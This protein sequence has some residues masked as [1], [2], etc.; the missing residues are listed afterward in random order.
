[1]CTI[2]TKSFLPFGFWSCRALSAA[3]IM[4]VV[5]FSWCFDSNVL[6]KFHIMNTA[7]AEYSLIGAFHPQKLDALATLGRRFHFSLGDEAMPDL[8]GAIGGLNSVPLSSKSLRGKVVLVDIWTYTCI[9][10][11]RP[12]PYV[13]S[14]AERYRSATK[15]VRFVVRLDAAAP[16]ENCGVDT[17]PDGSGEI[18]E[19]RLYQLIRQEAQA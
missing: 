7:K 5:A 1:M 12:L 6:A 11:L 16:G 15:P 9:N 18:R 14:W 8:G 4:G 2:N 19:A 10:S 17:A 3:V 13:K